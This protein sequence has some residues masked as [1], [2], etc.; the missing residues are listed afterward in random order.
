M[1]RQDVV[2]V[3]VGVALAAVLVFL[4]L[5]DPEKFFTLAAAGIALG[6]VYALVSLGFVVV[7]R[8]TGVLNFAQVGL[9]V[10][11][12]FFMNNATET[13]GWSF[14]PAI[15][16]TMVVT[17][18]LAVLI[19]RVAMRRML[20]KPLF[21]TILLT[22]GLFLVLQSLVTAIWPDFEGHVIDNPWGDAQV[23]IGNVTIRNVDVAAFVAG[24]AILIGF[25]LLFRFTKVG[26]A[27]RA[28]A[29]DQEAALAQGISVPRVVMLSWG[30]AGVVAVIAGVMLGSNATPKVSISAAGI[31][32]VALAAFPAMVLGGLDSPGGAV[33]GG[34]VIGLAYEL[35]L[36]YQDQY[37]STLGTGFAEVM[38]YL[39]MIVILLIRPS[40]LFG[41][42][43]VRRI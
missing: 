31:A 9:V 26:L 42:G 21:S 3:V 18:A 40:G 38:P 4:A 35:A 36:G 24:A 6:T 32:S 25:F 15:A 12:A 30:I 34:L 17:A 29:V 22:I 8:A 37:L 19:E 14:W 7:Y 13:W 43:E 33:V 16:V 27:M 11:G 1:K 23:T 5:D 41:T 2:L 20:G 28:T 39:V 10:F